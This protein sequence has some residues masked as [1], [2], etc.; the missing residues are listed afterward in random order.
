MNDP[1]REKFFNWVI[2]SFRVSPEGLALYRIFTALF[3]LL[4]LLPPPSMYEFV[5]SLPS[6]F[7]SPP[8]GP[9]QFFSDFPSRE[10]F[11]VLHF[12]LIISLLGMLLGFKTRIMS[13]A[14]GLILFVIKGFFYSVGK[15]NH[16]MLLI[17]VPI[18]MSFSGW[19]TAWSLD[20][21][22]KGE[23]KRK[24]TGW[25]LT[26]LSLILGFMMFTAGF[27]KLIGGWLN[28]D[29]QA[30]LGHF[31]NQFFVK[32]RSDLLAESFLLIDNRTLW[33]VLDYLT[34]LFEMG[35][36]LA[37][38]RPFS[39]RIFV[40]FAI[41]FHF[42]TMMMLNISF[43]HNFVAYAAFINWTFV[44]R[45]L[46][47]ATEAQY[48]P[49]LTLGLGIIGVRLLAWV[50]TRYHVPVLNSDLT[51]AHLYVLL[52]AL[53]IALFFLSRAFYSAFNRLS[54]SKMWE[55]VPG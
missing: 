52:L 22:I 51:T 24:I 34:V 26:L 16:E 17:I 50:G 55:E 39:T 36:L 31:F 41:L 47:K 32:G 37:V 25:P 4:F 30:V 3:V 45:K 42:S 21:W 14:V 35:F 33:E 44:Y 18:L 1:K 49:P 54:R 11:W 7:F 12:L 5:G 15:I 10:F 9:M 2:N 40:S 20:A 19:G 43:L 8:P 28:P 13:L 48:G 29:T 46:Q 6:D 38:V 53:P 27:T 23:Q